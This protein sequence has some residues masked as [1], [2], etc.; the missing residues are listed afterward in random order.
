METN[1]KISGTLG[2]NPHRNGVQKRKSV[3][4][5][6]DI[7]E[8]SGV[9]DGRSGKSSKSKSDGLTKNVR[10]Q[11]E[12]IAVKTMTLVIRGTSSLIVHGWDVKV[13]AEMLQM[14]MATKEER[15]KAKENRKVKD[16]ERDFEGAKYIIEGKDCFPVTGIKKALIDAGYAVGIPKTQIRQA[17]FIVGTVGGSFAEIKYRKC[18]MR[19]DTV[20]V[21]PWSNRVAD[22]RYRP[23]YQDWSIKLTIRY[24]TD[25]LDE[26]QVAIL[27][28]NAGVSI[29]LGEWRVQKDGL[30]GCFEVA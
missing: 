11:L 14:Q 5:A 7:S 15:K 9:L 30:F 8:V 4:D 26:K 23:E 27:F 24:R 22:L 19:Q 16:P 25:M 6:E 17:L 29:G 1:S 10:I 18:V 21:G 12:P 28:Q 20:R 2:G 3:R 13:Q